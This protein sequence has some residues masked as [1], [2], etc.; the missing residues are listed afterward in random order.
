MVRDGV[1]HPIYT[2]ITIYASCTLLLAF[3]GPSGYVHF[4]GD[5][6]VVG[7]CHLRAVGKSGRR[8]NPG[9]GGLIVEEACARL[10]VRLARHWVPFPRVRELRIRRVQL[11]IRFVKKIAHSPGRWRVRTPTCPAGHWQPSFL[12]S[13]GPEPRE[14]SVDRRLSR[15]GKMTNIPK[16]LDPFP[17]SRNEG[18]GTGIL[19]RGQ[20]LFPLRRSRNSSPAQNIFLLVLRGGNLGRRDQQELPR[21]ALSLLATACPLLSRWA[22]LHSRPAILECTCPLDSCLAREPAFFARA[23]TTLLPGR[24][25]SPPPM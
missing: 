22:V 23:R 13:S 1:Q 8:A 14:Y 6:A 2:S 9:V 4:N 10:R 21:A 19:A 20:S 7:W 16:V 5:G 17:P 18:A 12:S 15:A 3:C 11:L 24:L 25:G